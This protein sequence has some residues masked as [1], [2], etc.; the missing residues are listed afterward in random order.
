[1][2]DQ[3]AALSERDAMSARL[4]GFLESY[5]GFLCP[6][7]IGTAFAHC[8][9]GAPIEVDGEPVSPLCVDHPCLLASYTGVP[10]LSIPIGLD[11]RG[12]PIG[13]QLIGRRWHDARVIGVGQAI[14]AVAGRL[15]PPAA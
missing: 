3:F 5:D 1:V 6:V 2:F 9:R 15:P 10:A 7:S 14:A 13:A 11:S 4:D 8:E 12:L